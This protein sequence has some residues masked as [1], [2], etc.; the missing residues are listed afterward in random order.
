LAKA[1]GEARGHRTHG[2]VRCVLTASKELTMAVRGVLSTHLIR[3]DKSVHM[4][5]VG[6]LA[7]HG[8][9]GGCGGGL[10]PHHIVL[11]EGGGAQCGSSE[12]RSPPR[13]H[14]AWAHSA[15]SA[16]AAAA[17]PLDLTTPMVSGRGRPG[18][19]G[20]AQATRIQALHAMRAVG[21]SPRNNLASGFSASV[22]YARLSTFR[23]ARRDAS[24][25]RDIHPAWQRWQWKW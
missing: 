24:I 11:S 19:S 8:R 2:C 13:P 5:G 6:D 17:E 25:M 3:Y 7:L 23:R 9:G 22:F 4:Q 16:G 20:L 1:A 18:R 14:S 15:A 12:S 21:D 10:D